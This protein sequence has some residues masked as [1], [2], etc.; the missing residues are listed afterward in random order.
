[1]S[2]VKP[3]RR[4][5]LLLLVAVGFV[6][7][8]DDS[9]LSCT[10]SACE[11][12]AIRTARCNDFQDYAC[13]CETSSYS[14]AFSSCLQSQTS[15]GCTD[16]DWQSV[17]SDIVTSCSAYT[18]SLGSSLCDECYSAGVSTLACLDSED[19]GCLCGD[20][21][22][23]FLDHLTSCAGVARSASATCVI[24]DLAY[25][26]GEFTSACSSYATE[27]ASVPGCP[28]C[29]SSAASLLQCS[30]LDDFACLCTKSD[31]YTSAVGQCISTE[32][33]YPSDLT[34]ARNTYTS[35]CAVVATGGSVP[36]ATDP[37]ARASGTA[38][39]GASQTAPRSTVDGGSDGPD[40]GTVA[41]IVAGVVAGLALLCVGG[42]FIFRRRASLRE[43]PADI[44]AHR[45][46]QS[47]LHAPGGQGPPN[48][49][50]YELSSPPGPLYQPQDFS[51][52]SY[53]QYQHPQPPPPQPA[54][55]P[56][57]YYY[58]LEH[59]HQYPPVGVPQH[60][61]VGSKPT[62]HEGYAELGTMR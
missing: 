36:A 17:S 54:G 37:V 45:P 13:F 4:A 5:A 62:Y 26:A 59:K 39:S 12:T 22:T 6:V 60:G 42:F 2:P 38:A 1:M 31:E 3:P 27:V 21:S 46:P 32:S 58:E 24:T 35:N 23:V 33:C 29:Q 43:K 14:S 61:N 7:G 56:G 47:H 57:G 40:A 19:Y 48:N 9:T 10:T 25:L 50:V 30:G 49:G 51:K 11:E 16:T 20:Q 18:S 15:L 53:A 55:G 41:G 28:L 8:Q 52:A 44:P 34:A